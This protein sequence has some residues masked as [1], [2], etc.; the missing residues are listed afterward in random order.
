[1]LFKWHEKEEIELVT[2]NKVLRGEIAKE[3]IR[4]FLYII[5]RNFNTFNR[6]ILNIKRS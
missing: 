2:I 1:M 6:T 4:R 5:K 3:N